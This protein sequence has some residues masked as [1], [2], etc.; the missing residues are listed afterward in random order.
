[1]KLFSRRDPRLVSAKS[2]DTRTGHPW[3]GTLGMVFK[4]SKPK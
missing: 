1:M 3:M 4:R 2:A